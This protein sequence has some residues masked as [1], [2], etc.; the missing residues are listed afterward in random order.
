MIKIVLLNTPQTWDWSMGTPFSACLPNKPKMR[1]RRSWE[2]SCRSG[3]I[4]NGMVLPSRAMDIQMNEND[5]LGDKFGELVEDYDRFAKVHPE[6]KFQIIQMLKNREWL[7]MA[8]TFR[9]PAAIVLTSPWLSVIACRE[10][11]ANRLKTTWFTGLRAH[12]NF[13]SSSRW[14]HC[15][16]TQRLS[17]V[18]MEVR[19]VRDVRCEQ[20]L[21]CLLRLS[22][23]F[24]GV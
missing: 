4:V 23:R 21:I 13:W 14:R 7:V 16:L 1:R 15:A 9:M 6:H 24:P 2:F 10:K 11:S 18:V 3:A 17:W 5:V 22:E 20:D 19:E 8:S 12:C